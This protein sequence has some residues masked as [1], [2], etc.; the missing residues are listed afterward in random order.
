[1]AAPP[2]LLERHRAGLGLSR[3]LPARSRSTSRSSAAASSASPPRGCSRIAASRSPWSRRARVGEEVTGK[4]TAKITSQHNI[5]YTTIERKFGEDGAR[6]YA[7]ANEAGLRDDPRARRAR[8]ASTAISR[9]KPAF[10]YTHDEDE[11][12]RDRGRGRARAAARPARLADPRHR[13][14]VRR[15][16]RRCAGTIRRSSTRSNM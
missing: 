13:P 14:A 1:M 10:T 16:A 11:V 6:L 2:I 5:A 7:E 8:T 9:R 3:A 12:A 4:S 15:A